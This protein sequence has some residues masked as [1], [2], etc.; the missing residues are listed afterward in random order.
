MVKPKERK[1][2]EKL[3]KKRK[4]KDQKEDIIEC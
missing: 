1:A 3:K 2:V 4:G